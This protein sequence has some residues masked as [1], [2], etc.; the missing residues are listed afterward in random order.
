MT[1]MMP[2]TTWTDP[3]DQRQGLLVR[4]SMIRK[5][6]KSSWVSALLTRSTATEAAAGQQ[7]SWR[8]ITGS[9]LY[10]LH[11]IYLGTCA[12]TRLELTHS[13]SNFWNKFRQLFETKVWS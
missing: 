9:E 5:E 8:I 12:M 10:I 13:S 4:H 6:K 7:Q 2:T 1:M 11:D 3:H